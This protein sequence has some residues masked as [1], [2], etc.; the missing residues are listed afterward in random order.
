MYF[1]IY[2]TIHIPI[3]LEELNE[4]AANELCEVYDA[5]SACPSE[6]SVL[7]DAE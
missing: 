6:N 2:L 3:G 4:P 5:V 1:P 7:H